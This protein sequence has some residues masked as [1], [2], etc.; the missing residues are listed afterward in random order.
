LEQ[1]CDWY[2]WIAAAPDDPFRPCEHGI[3]WRTPYGCY[4]ALALGR[5]TDMDAFLD[6]QG[7][8]GLV[9]GQPLFTELQ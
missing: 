7:D 5:M 9:R 3:H 8:M 4:S 1:V 2:E 6:G